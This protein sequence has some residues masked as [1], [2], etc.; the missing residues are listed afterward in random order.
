MFKINLHGVAAAG[1]SLHRNIL[2][3]LARPIARAAGVGAGRPAFYKDAKVPSPPSPRDGRATRFAKKVGA[4][5]NPPSPAAPQKSSA[6]RAAAAKRAVEQSWPRIDIRWGAG[7]E[8]LSQIREQALQQSRGFRQPA[9]PLPI[10]QQ[11][12]PLNIKLDY[13]RRELLPRLDAFQPGAFDHLL[14][15]PKPGQQA[16]A[17]QP[18]AQQRQPAVQQ[19]GVRRRQQASPQP[20]ASP[21]EQAL[22]P[23]GHGAALAA[24]QQRQ[25]AAAAVRAKQ[26]QG[27]AEGPIPTIKSQKV[28]VGRGQE[29]MRSLQAEDGTT[30]LY[31]KSHIQGGFGRFHRATRPG[32]EQ[33]GLKQVR[34]PYNPV[35]RGQR[36]S[37]VNYTRTTD[38]QREAAHMRALGIKV[39]GVHVTPT[40]KGF[41]E[42]ELFTGS[43]YEKLHLV[44]IA[45]RAA[46][47]RHSLKSLMEQ[48]AG[49]HAAGSVHRDIKNDNLLFNAEGRIQIGD[50]GLLITQD[51]IA[52]YTEAD[53]AG[54]ARYMPP[55]SFGKGRA[56]KPTPAVDNWAAGCAY[57]EQLTHSWPLGYVHNNEMATSL[58][59]FEHERQSHL[60]GHGPV[61]PRTPWANLIAHAHKVDSEGTNFV[62]R[63]LMAPK[64]ED[65]ISAA[66]AAQRLDGLAYRRRPTSPD[67]IAGAAAQGLA[68]AAWEP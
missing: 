31:E 61:N 44:P 50:P 25:E 29:R 21:A 63:Y 30:L 55:E 14:R 18:V 47:A 56:S 3:L 58:R 39:Y 57:L 20:H 6:S 53:A 5:F 2:K 11:T 52:R 10:L 24:A 59:G 42:T 48:L 22:G 35:K 26:P 15:S 16:V 65:R 13:K 1:K 8:Q 49:L 12:P 45:R 23:L 7:A 32:G 51:Q 36:K 28:K 19:P 46:V 68:V 60:L 54:T 67:G 64:P 43:L 37:M 27:G 66:Q 34:L 33:R 40:G 38:L 41:I 62:L 4:F 17:Q 9:A